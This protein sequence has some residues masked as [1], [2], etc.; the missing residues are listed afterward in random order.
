M[1]ATVSTG[2][3]AGRRRRCHAAAAIPPQHHTCLIQNDQ[4]NSLGRRSVFTSA[5]LS[6]STH[7]GIIVAEVPC[8]DEF[9]LQKVYNGWFVLRIDDMKQHLPEG[10]RR[11]LL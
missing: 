5:S 7:G 8:V 2:R 3:V 10:S 11:L 4:K 9:R 6:S 1:A